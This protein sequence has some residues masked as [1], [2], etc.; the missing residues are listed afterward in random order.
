MP[1]HSTKD[2]VQ[3]SHD[4]AG[5]L[6]HELNNLLAVIGGHA[7]ALE[8]AVPAEGPDHASL[9]AIQRAVRSAASVADRVRRLG[10]PAGGTVRG[11]DVRPVVERASADAMRECGHRLNVAVHAAPRLWSVSVAPALV[12]QVLW[13]LMARAADVMPHGG[14]L[15]VRCMNV[16][17]GA[18]PGRSAARRDRHVRVELSC[19]TLLAG[20]ALA[21]PDAEAGEDNSLFEALSRAGGRLSVE[22]DGA[23][24]VIWA[25]LLP[26]DGIEPLR[27]STDVTRRTGEILLLDADEARRGVM[28]SLLERH[29]YAV[30]AVA[31]V[32]DAALALEAAPADLLVAD[33]ASRGPGGDVATLVRQHAVR[34]LRIEPQGGT[35]PP[36]VDV[37]S[38]RT[39]RAPLSAGQLVEG[40]EAALDAEHASFA[41]PR[42][43]AYREAMA[44][45]SEGIA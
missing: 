21:A 36:G 9:E 39:L 34:V 44:M 10:R 30:R 18:A 5:Q 27:P 1:I 20:E 42:L 17:L 45:H 26:S 29:G 23:T 25:L 8:P 14:T 40:V 16:E 41:R 24:M 38:A 13:R 6:A 3:P 33:A 43:L 15:A 7:D 11:V 35:V 31:S 32:E 4:D 12:E 2:P 19:P 22:S 37:P 28:R